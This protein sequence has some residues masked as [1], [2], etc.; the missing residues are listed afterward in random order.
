MSSA[1]RLVDILF[2]NKFQ[3]LRRRASRMLRIS[4]QVSQLV[5]F[6][7]DLISS[8]TVEA[9]VENMSFLQP[10]YFAIEIAQ[11]TALT[12]ASYAELHVEGFANASIKVPQSSLTTTPKA[13]SPFL[14]AASQF[15]FPC[16]VQLFMM[17]TMFDYSNRTC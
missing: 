7:V 12:S 9:S 1:R 2:Q 11:L 8:T 3:L 17:A 13:A 4:S 16:S 6:A 15:T 10:F 5:G 14:K